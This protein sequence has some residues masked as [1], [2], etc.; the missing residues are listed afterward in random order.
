MLFS[1]L[2]LALTGCGKDEPRL[3]E[4]H[5]TVINK[6]TRQPVPNAVVGFARFYGGSWLGGSGRADS[7][8]KTRT[9]AAGRYSVSFTGPTQGE[10][11]ARIEGPLY[12]P[13]LGYD[14]GYP[15]SY[16]VRNELHLEVTPLKTVTVNVN[17]SKGGKSDIRFQFMATDQGPWFNA[18]FIFIDTI[19]AN[20]TLRFTRQV[21]VVPN[22]QYR[23][24][25]YI[26]N[27]YLVPGTNT[28]QYR[29]ESGVS[30]D[31]F[32]GYNDTTVI[33]FN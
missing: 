12:D 11:I 5:G 31:R 18:G 24:H 15:V 20:Q 16:G 19:R 30:I 27:R 26:A 25:Q 8:S 28:S 1:L 4:V 17:V 23:F 22:R 14:G 6:Y 33:N 3:T 7:V 10:Y 21:P 29:D 2:L 9:D 32:V 13:V